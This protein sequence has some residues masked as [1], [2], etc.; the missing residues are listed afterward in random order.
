MACIFYNM[1]CVF[2][3][4]HI[5]GCFFHIWRFAT[6]VFFLHICVNFVDGWERKSFEYDGNFLTLYVI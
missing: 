2:S 6:V 4:A 3:V 1:P 5:R